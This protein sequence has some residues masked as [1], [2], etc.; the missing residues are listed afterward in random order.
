MTKRTKE[1][2][3][4]KEDWSYG[5][6]ARDMRIEAVKN[7]GIKA[8]TAVKMGYVITIISF[9]DVDI[10]IDDDRITIYGNT[11]PFRNRLKD[12][13]FKWLPAGK[14]WVLENK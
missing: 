10:D 5:A 1:I 4:I 9:N 8:D 7:L 11:Y 14:I 3:Q 2:N 12:N 13:G 6:A